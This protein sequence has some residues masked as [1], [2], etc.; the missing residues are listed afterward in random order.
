[1][2]ESNLVRA[3]LR[4][5]CANR[6]RENTLRDLTGCADGLPPDLSADRRYREELGS[7]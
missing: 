2:S 3:A 4:E 1:M 7:D 6:L 5:Y